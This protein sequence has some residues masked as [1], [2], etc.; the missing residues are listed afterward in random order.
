[1]SLRVKNEVDRFWCSTPSRD[2]LELR[3][4]YKFPIDPDCLL[5]NLM[6][7]VFKY[8]YVVADIIWENGFICM[9]D[10][11]REQLGFIEYKP[12]T[13]T[14]VVIV[15]VP[16]NCN[17]T[18]K[19]GMLMRYIIESIETTLEYFYPKLGDVTHRLIPCS[20]CLLRRFD[21]EPY[22]FSYEEC[23]EAVTSGYPVVYCNNIQSRS[24]SVF[25]ES[26]APDITFVDF[27]NIKETDL[28]IGE[29]LGQGSF[30]TVYSGQWKGKPVAIKTIKLFNNIEKASKFWDFQQESF[31]MR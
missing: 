22:C 23:V 13:T 19:S 30:G 5:V 21:F 7:R 29:E 6:R 20:H 12:N 18:T 24:R 27:P 31:I 10:P 15:R 2:I 26:L 9:L 25:I 11:T 16:V 17:Y 4:I 8:K 3:R 1:M 28:V 14:L